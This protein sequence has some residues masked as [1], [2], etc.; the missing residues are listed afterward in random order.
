MRTFPSSLNLSR[1]LKKKYFYCIKPKL[2]LV[3]PIYIRVYKLRSNDLLLILNFY[4]NPLPRYWRVRVLERDA[5]VRKRIGYSKTITTVLSL[6]FYVITRK[7]IA[8]DCYHCRENKNKYLLRVSRT[9]THVYNIIPHAL[10]VTVY[11][12]RYSYRG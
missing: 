9:R 12:Y 7:Y 11:V 2:V 1:I 8:F 3:H 10:R 6:L 4:R 5:C